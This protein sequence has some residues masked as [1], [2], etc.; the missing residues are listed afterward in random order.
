LECSSD[1]IDILP[2][3]PQRTCMQLVQGAYFK[4]NR[5]ET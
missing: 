1:V 4:V 3:R 5:P 2:A